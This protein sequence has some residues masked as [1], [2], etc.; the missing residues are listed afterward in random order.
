MNTREL[1]VHCCTPYKAPRQVVP[2]V[3]GACRDVPRVVQIKALELGRVACERGRDDELDDPGNAGTDAGAGARS[4][5][6]N[7][8][9]THTG[10]AASVEPPSLSCCMFFALAS[11]P[12]FGCQTVGGPLVGSP[13]P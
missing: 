9:E 8:R 11:S 12:T 10:V 6:R 7:D 4:R 5:A 3:H 1:A 13:K 2:V